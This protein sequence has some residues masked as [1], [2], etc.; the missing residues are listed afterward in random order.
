MSEFNTLSDVHKDGR[1]QQGGDGTHFE[2]CE[3]SHW[4]CKI[5]S[6]SKQITTLR[7]EKTELIE[8]L[9]M[10]A[11]QY[12]TFGEGYFMH[13]FMSAGENALPLLEKYGQLKK[14]DKAKWVRL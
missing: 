3:E 6:Q 1:W 4:D 7:E 12:L 11:E 13:D 9:M 8:V 10:M 5:L 2:G 14:V